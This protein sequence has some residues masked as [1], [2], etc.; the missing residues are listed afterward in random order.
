M[1]S[2]YTSSADLYDLIYTSL[3]DYA[4]EARWLAGL[5][6][7]LA[8]GA[9]TLLDVACG[10]GEHARWLS[11]GHGLQVDGIDLDRELVTLAAAKHREGTFRCADM[12]DF[13]LGRRYDVVT[14]LFG[15]I[16]YA[17]G[18]AALGR[19]MRCMAAHLCPGGL[20][21]V[22][23]F[24]SPGAL[25][26]GRVTTRAVEAGGIGICRMTHATVAGTEARIA[27]EYLVGREAG[28][29]RRSELHELSLYTEE[30]LTASL[31]AAG[32][33]VETLPGG[34]DGRS[35]HVGRRR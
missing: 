9:R 1:G 33:V 26:P 31:R 21:L 35:L 6:Q 8:P 18:I 12:T 30:E 14:C 24:L 16:A 28:I 4:A 10:T 2:M 15:S 23:P 20:L 32:L 5:L 7:E 19:A 34:L 13:D 22:E 17:R 27:F 11:A 25:P 29:E 3:K